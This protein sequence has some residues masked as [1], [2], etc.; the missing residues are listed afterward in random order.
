MEEM[1]KSMLLQSS[2]P[3]KRDRRIIFT[4]TLNNAQSNDETS[5]AW[6]KSNSSD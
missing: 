6:T 3:F 2:S 4:I 1:N 5:P